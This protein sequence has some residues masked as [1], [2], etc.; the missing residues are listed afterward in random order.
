MTKSIQLKR[1]EL[2]SNFTRGEFYDLVIIGAGISGLSTGLM[3]QKNTENKRTL[4]IEKNAYPGGTVQLMN[5]R[6]MYLKQP[7]FFRISLI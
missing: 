7:N 1:D 2:K 6:D 3:W 5:N 4:I